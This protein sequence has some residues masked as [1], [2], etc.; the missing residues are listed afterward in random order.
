MTMEV[1]LE[2]L[3]RSPQLSL[4]VKRLQE[5]LVSEQQRRE[6]FYRTIKE[7]DKVE[8]IN[9]Q[10]IFH[11]PVKF[12]HATASQDLFSLLDAY[13]KTQRLGFVGHEKVM[14]ALTRNDYEPDVCFFVQAKAS[15]FTPDQMKFP[16]PDLIAEVLS[17]STE[18][19]DR[20]VKFEDY[21]AHGVGEYWLV[22]TETET[23]EQY[24]LRGEA[25]VL[26]TKARTG[27]I[28]SEVAQGFEIPMRA[29]FDADEN[30][31]TLQRLVSVH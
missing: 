14:I 28:T 2:S 31:A 16:A 19:Y 6:E 18:A 13:I 4:Y 12:R 15:Q 26:L 20:N 7:D 9:G 17:P 21:A 10:V 29:I 3:V 30:L 27:N 11:S 22:D 5:I 24:V 23:I 1:V 8:F 25:Y